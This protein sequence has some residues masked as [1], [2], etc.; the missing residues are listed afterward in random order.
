MCSFLYNFVCCFYFVLFVIELFPCSDQPGDYRCKLAWSY[1]PV[2]CIKCWHLCLTCTLAL[3]NKYLLNKIKKENKQVCVIQVSCCPTLSKERLESPRPASPAR[4][5]R[6]SMRPS[7]LRSI[8]SN[9][10][11]QLFS[12]SPSGPGDSLSWQ[13]ARGNQGHWIPITG[14]T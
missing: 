7:W 1:N 2:R 4:R 11:T 9:S 8:L 3:L 13:C 12:L 6:M 5:S 10:L 14:A